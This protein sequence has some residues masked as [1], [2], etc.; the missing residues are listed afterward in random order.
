ML[1]IVIIWLLVTGILW[2]SHR[3]GHLKHD[4]YLDACALGA[5]GLVTVGFF[6][7]LFSTPKVWMPV[8]GGDLVSFLYPL[9]SFSARSLRAGDIPLWN[10]YLYGGAPFAADN[11]SGL[12]YPVN[13]LFFLWNPHLSFEAMQWLSVFHFYLAGI[14][15]YLGLRYIERR[16]MKR[17]AALA[18]ASA[19]M[20]SDLFVTHFGNLN[21]IACAAW[22]PLIFCLFRRAL[23]EHRLGLAAGAGAF[24]GVAALAGHIQPL[25]YI[26]LGL[27]LYWLYHLYN[28]RP[29]KW[30]SLVCAAAVLAVTL[31]V[32]AGVAAPS[33]VPAYEMSRLTVRADLTYAD[34]SQYSLPPTALIGLVVP[35]IFGRGPG[36][37][38][39][40]WPRVEVGYVGILTLLLAFLAVLLRRD[41]LTGFFALLAIVAVFL[42]FGNLS[43]LHG[44]LYR[45]VPGFNLVRAPARFI[46]LLDFALASLAALGLDALLRPIPH[47]VRKVWAQVLRRLPSVLLGT[48][49]VVLSVSYATLL[50]NQDKAPE[51]FSHMVS[52]TSGIAFALGLL[53]CGVALVYARQSRWAR[54]SSIGLLTVA[55]IV[56]DLASLGA[57]TE[58]ETSDPTTGFQ[59]TAAIAFLK[60]DPDY[61]RIDTRTEVWDV[62]QP[63][64]SLMQSIH[65][66]WGIY[67]PLVLADWNRYWE[68]LGSRSS[69]LYD[70]LNCKYVI[71]HKDVVLDWDKFELAFDGDPQVNIYRNKRVLPRA[72]VVF[73]TWVVPNQ[74]AA[75]EAIH[76]AD[77]QPAVLAAIEGGE[78]L[79]AGAQGNSEVHIT[80]YS[81]NEILLDA[82][83]SLPGCLV[84][85]EVAYPGW[86]VEVD[87][88]PAALHRANY[89]FR[90]VF[91]APGTH[92][93]RF[94]FQPTSWRV[95]L[96]CGLCTV[97]ALAIVGMMNLIRTFRGRTH[98]L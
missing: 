83:T 95:G 59:H 39:G 61:Y 97:L 16:P 23:D 36:G 5:L 49:V 50:S 64:L 35:S 82:T 78:T 41:K 14:C 43:I 46:Y 81:N 25:L 73:Q 45:L 6:W 90:S 44:W 72:F 1:F 9:Y 60:S 76:R 4:Y 87:G 21:M 75:F 19:F 89:T 31:G 79:D 80:A 57:Y 58:L 32:A 17:W 77:F 34:A 69:P 2:Q 30:R 42:S 88:K 33:L 92:Q 47:S 62:W 24:L 7:R 55:L 68:G 15:A 67:N 18:G 98:R 74:E 85:S 53:G 11:Q 28:Q 38:W 86:K 37:Y 13:L 93:V 22:L 84:L 8:G 71:A 66:V 51:V 26:V 63:D 3:H 54:R 96:V 91:L 65:D 27:G 48:T 56:V 20:F 70:L 12:F 40:P 52:G 29:W 94:Y 10:P